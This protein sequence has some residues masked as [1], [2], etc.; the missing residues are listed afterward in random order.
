MVK[1]ALLCLS[2]LL[3]ALDPSNWPAAAAPFNLLLTFLADQRPKVRKRA[4]TGLVEVLA[5]LQGGPA[6]APASEALARGAHGCGGGG[7][8]GGVGWGA[9]GEDE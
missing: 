4:H 7:G 2:Y 1:P 8:R 5:A 9:T 6:L 3:A